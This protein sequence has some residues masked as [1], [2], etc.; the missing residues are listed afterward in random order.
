VLVRTGSTIAGG[1]AG[2][3]LMSTSLIHRSPQ[4][5]SCVLFVMALLLGSLN[6]HRWRSLIL[7]T[8]MMMVSVKITIGG[9]HPLV[10][11]QQ[12]TQIPTENMK[13]LDR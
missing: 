11:F 13:L 3:L 6:R 8:L 1:A 10:V 2:Y 12:A 4:L 5:L 7:Y 9:C